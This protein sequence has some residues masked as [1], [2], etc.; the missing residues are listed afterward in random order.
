[1]LLVGN[2]LLDRYDKRE[3][4]IHEMMAKDEAKD[5]QVSNAR[6]TTE[7]FAHCQATGLRLTDKMLCHRDSFETGMKCYLFSNAQSVRKTPQSGAMV[8]QWSRGRLLAPKCS[9]GMDEKIAVKGKLLLPLILAHHVDISIKSKLD[10][11]PKKEEG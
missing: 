1:M 8:S 9:T 3:D 5:R 2:E 10:F 7:R 11:T 6:L 4:D